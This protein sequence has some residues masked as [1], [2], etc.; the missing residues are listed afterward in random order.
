MRKV[1]DQRHS[2][3]RT[4]AAGSDNARYVNNRAVRGQES[5]RASY[6]DAGVE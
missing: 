5:V 6:M 4:G 3:V 1:T 2:A